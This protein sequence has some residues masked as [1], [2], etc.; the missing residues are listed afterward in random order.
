MST[1]AKCHLINKNILFSSFSKQNVNFFSTFSNRN[2]QCLVHRKWQ[3]SVPSIY[4]QIV[5]ASNITSLLGCPISRPY[6]SDH[7]DRHRQIKTPRL[8][9]LMAFPKIIWPSFFKSIKNW[10]LINFIICPYF[11]REFDIQEFA[12]G[13]KHALQ[14]I[15]ELYFSF[16]Y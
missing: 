13:T 9:P 2:N 4:Q 16:F 1:V 6:C 10:I 7:E 8:P 14:V 11:D 3:A 15:S 5:P 12:V